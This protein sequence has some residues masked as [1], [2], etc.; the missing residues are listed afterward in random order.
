MKMSEVVSERFR[1]PQSQDF[2]SWMKRFELGAQCTNL[3][4]EQK[5]NSFLA[6]LESPCQELAMS[7]VKKYKTD[8]EP[9]TSPAADVRA[10]HKDLWKDLIAYVSKKS[11][12]V[13][14]RPELRLHNQWSSLR[15]KEHE[16]VGSY[17]HRLE[18]LKCQMAEQDKPFLADDMTTW[19]TFVN[20][21][22]EEIRWHIKANVKGTDLEDTLERAEAYEEANKS[23][24]PQRNGKPEY[25][26][27]GT[28]QNAAPLERRSGFQ[29]DNS[30]RARGPRAMAVSDDRRSRRPRPGRSRS[31]TSAM[32]TTNDDQR[33]RPPPAPKKALPE[34]GSR[35]EICFPF[36]KNQTCKHADNCFRI[37]V[38]NLDQKRDVRPSVNKVVTEEM[39]EKCKRMLNMQ[40]PRL[41]TP[42]AAA[43]QDTPP[44]G[45]APAEE[46]SDFDFTAATFVVASDTVLAGDSEERPGVCDMAYSPSSTPMT[47]EEEKE[48]DEQI[49]ELLEDIGVEPAEWPKDGAVPKLFS[50]TSTDELFDELCAQISQEVDED[51]SILV[52]MVTTREDIQPPAETVGEANPAP[53]GHRV[54]WEYSWGPGDPCYLQVVEPDYLDSFYEQGQSIPVMVHR[55]LQACHYRTMH[56]TQA[57]ELA[58]I[59]LDDH[60]P[61]LAGEACGFLSSIYKFFKND[62]PVTS[63]LLLSWLAHRTARP[64]LSRDEAR[65]RAGVMPQ[66]RPSQSSLESHNCNMTCAESDRAEQALLRA[67]PEETLDEAESAD[68]QHSTSDDPTPELVD[69]PDTSSEADSLDEAEYNELLVYFTCYD[70]ECNMTCGEEDR[71]EQARLQAWHGNVLDADEEMLQAVEYEANGPRPTPPPSPAT[72]PPPSI[73]ASNLGGVEDSREQLLLQIFHEAAQQYDDRLLRAVAEQIDELASLPIFPFNEHD[74]SPPDATCYTAIGD[75]TSPETAAILKVYAGQ[76]L[77]RALIDTGSRVNLI[78]GEL[79]DYI[80]GA[81][82]DEPGVVHKP[83]ERVSG[84]LH[85]ASTHQLNIRGETTLRLTVVPGKFLLAKFLVA[86]RLMT[87]MIWGDHL[88]GP[89]QLDCVIDLGSKQMLTRRLGLTLDLDIHNRAELR[90]RLKSAAASHKRKEQ[91]KPLVPGRES[92]RPPKLVRSLSAMTVD[93]ARDVTES[94]VTE[95]EESESEHG[96]IS[97]DET[98]QRVRNLASFQRWK[99]NQRRKNQYRRR[100]PL[101]ADDPTICAVVQFRG[102]TLAAMQRGMRHGIGESD[103]Y[104]IC[105]VDMK[106]GELAQTFYGTSPHREAADWCGGSPHSADVI[107][108]ICRQKG[109]QS[110]SHDRRRLSHKGYRW[111]FEGDATET[112]YKPGYQERAATR[113]A[114][115]ENTTSAR[116]R[117][118]TSKIPVTRLTQRNEEKPSVCVTQPRDSKKRRMAAQPPSLPPSEPTSRSA[119]PVAPSRTYG[120]PRPEVLHGPRAP[121][122]TTATTRAPTMPPAATPPGPARSQLPDEDRP[123]VDEEMPPLV[124]AWLQQQLTQLE[125]IKRIEQICALANFDGSQS[126]LTRSPDSLRSSSEIIRFTWEIREPHSRPRRD[127][128]LNKTPSGPPPRFDSQAL[129]LDA[130]Q[131]F[132]TAVAEEEPTAEELNDDAATKA[133]FLR[134]KPILEE[135]P[136]E[137]RRYFRRQRNALRKKILDKLTPEER[138]QFVVSAYSDDSS[139]ESSECYEPPS[140]ADLDDESAEHPSSYH[141]DDGDDEMEDHDL[142]E[143]DD[144]DDAD[145]SDLEDSDCDESR[146]A[147]FAVFSHDDDDLLPDNLASP[148]DTQPSP[149][150]SERPTTT[151]TPVLL[152]SSAPNGEDARHARAGP[153][154]AP[155]EDSTTLPVNRVDP[156]LLSRAISSP[157]PDSDEL[158]EHDEVKVAE[159][160]MHVVRVETGEQFKKLQ[161]A[162]KALQR[163]RHQK[164]IARASP[165]A[166]VTSPIPTEPDSP[167]TDV[168]PSAVEVADS[169]SPCISSTVSPL[170]AR[171]DQLG[172]QILEQERQLTTPT[173]GSPGATLSPLASAVNDEFRQRRP[174]AMSFCACPRRPSEVNPHDLATIGECASESNRPLREAATVVVASPECDPDT[175]LMLRRN[176]AAMGLPRTC[177]LSADEFEYLGPSPRLTVLNRNPINA[178]TSIKFFDGKPR[179]ILCIDVKE[180]FVYSDQLRPSPVFVEQL[181]HNNRVDRNKLEITQAVDLQ[182]SRN[183]FPPITIPALEHGNLRIT[184]P[185]SEAADID[186]GHCRFSELAEPV[187]RLTS[188]EKLIVFL[189]YHWL[190]LTIGFTHGDLE[191]SNIV[192]ID[193]DLRLVDFETSTCDVAGVEHMFSA[194]SPRRRQRDFERIGVPENQYD[195]WRAYF[196]TADKVRAGLLARMTARWDVPDTVDYDYAAP[197]ALDDAV[198]DASAAAEDLSGVVVCNAVDSKR[199]PKKRKAPSDEDGEPP[200]AS[201]Q[202]RPRAPGLDRKL[203]AIDEE[204]FSDTDIDSESEGR[205]LGMETAQEWA[206]DCA[207]EHAR[208]RQKCPRCSPDGSSQTPKDPRCSCYHGYRRNLRAQEAQER[209]R[210]AEWD[211]MYLDERAQWRPCVFKSPFSLDPEP[212]VSRIISQREIPVLV[213]TGRGDS[214]RVDARTLREYCENRANRPYDNELSPLQYSAFSARLQADAAINDCERCSDIMSRKEGR[215]L[216][217]SCL[218]PRGRA[219]DMADAA[220]GEL[221]LTATPSP[222]TADEARRKLGCP[223]WNHMYR[224]ATNTWT[225]CELLSPA[226]PGDLDPDVRIR[227]RFRYGLEAD[228]P[229]GRLAPLDYDQLGRLTTPDTKKDAVT[230]CAAVSSP[231]TPQ[232]DEIICALYSGSRQVAKMFLSYADAAKWCGGNRGSIWRACRSRKA[233]RVHAGYHWRYAST[234]TKPPAVPLRP[235]PRL[236]GNPRAVT[237]IDLH[238]GRAV[239]TFR[240]CVEAAQWCEGTS[241]AI[242]KIC[243]RKSRCSHHKGYGW[244]DADLATS[245]TNS[246]AQSGTQNK[247]KATKRGSPHLRVITAMVQPAVG[248]AKTPDVGAAAFITLP[249]WCSDQ[250]DHADPPD[251][252]ESENSRG[253]PIPTAD[254]PAGTPMWCYSRTSRAWVQAHFVRMDTPIHVT[255]QF[256]CGLMDIPRARCRKWRRTWPAQV[257]ASQIALI[258]EREALD[259]QWWNNTPTATPD[260]IAISRE[261]PLTPRDVDRV[262]HRW[263]RNPWNVDWSDPNLDSD[264]NSIAYARR[265]LLEEPGHKVS[266]PMVT[267]RGPLPMLYRPRA[268]TAPSDGTNN[269][270]ETRT[271]AL[272]PPLPLDLP[273]G[274]PLLFLSRSANQWKRAAFEGHAASPDLPLITISVFSTPTRNG[275]EVVYRRHLMDL[276]V[277]RCREYVIGKAD[278][279]VTPAEHRLVAV[280]E[281]RANALMHGVDVHPSA[282]P[283]ICQHAPHTPR[284]DQHSRSRSSRYRWNQIPVASRQLCSQSTRTAQPSSLLA[285]STPAGAETYDLTH[286]LPRSA[287][288]YTTP[289]SQ[290]SLQEVS[291]IQGL[292]D[293]LSRPS[294]TNMVEYYEDETPER[295]EKGDCTWDEICSD[296]Y[297]VTSV[298]PSVFDDPTKIPVVTLYAGIGGFSLGLAHTLSGPQLSPRIYVPVLAI[299]SEQLIHAAHQLT[300]PGIPCARFFMSETQDTLALIETYLP[301]RLW[302]RAWVHASPS[303]R[304]ASAV[305]VRRDEAMAYQT[306]AWAVNLMEIMRPAIWTLEQAPTLRDYFADEYPLVAN[307]RMADHCTLPQDRTRMIISS[308][309]LVLPERPVHQETVRSALCE[310]RGWPAEPFSSAHRIRNSYYNERGIDERAFAVTSG[311]H[312]VGALP[313]EAWNEKH[314]MSWIERARL[315]GMRDPSCLKFLAGTNEQMRRKMVANCVPPPFSA[316]IQVAVDDALRTNSTSSFALTTPAPRVRAH[317][318]TNVVAAAATLEHEVSG[319]SVPA[320]STSHGAIETADLPTIPAAAGAP[321]GLSSQAAIFE[322]QAA[323][324]PKDTASH[325]ARL[326]PT[327]RSDLTQLDAMSDADF[328]AEVNRRIP[329]TGGEKTTTPFGPT[330]TRAELYLFG[331]SGELLALP[332]EARVSVPSVAA[333]NLEQALYDLAM[334]VALRIGYRLAA[335]TGWLH[336]TTGADE[337]EIFTSHGCKLVDLRE[338]L[339]ADRSVWPEPVWIPP[340]DFT[341]YRW[342]RDDMPARIS[343]AVRACR[344]SSDERK[345]LSLR[346]WRVAHP[347]IAIDDD[348]GPPPANHSWAVRHGNGDVGAQSDLVQPITRK[349]FE[350]LFK[351]GTPDCLVHNS[352]NARQ[353]AQMMDLLWR[354]RTLFLQPSRLGCADVPPHEIE[355]TVDKPIAQQPYRTNPEKQAIIMKEVDKLKKL[356]CVEDSNSPWASPVVLVQ[357]P[358][359]SWRFCVDYRALNAHTVRDVYPLPRIQDTLHLLN[360]QRYFTTLDLLQGFFQL[361]LSE[362]AKKKT[363]FVTTQGLFQFRALAMGLA[364]A[365]ATFQRCVD[366][367]M[368]GLKWKCVLVYIDD[369][370]VYSPTWE[371]HLL[372]LE[373]VFDRLSRHLLFVKPH[374]CCFGADSLQYL[375]HVVTRDGLKPSTKHIDAVREFP[376]PTTKTQ[377]K[378]FLGLA[379]FNRAFI[380]NFAKVTMPLRHLLSNDIPPN[381]HMPITLTE[382]QAPIERSLWDEDCET[383]FKRLKHLLTTAPILAFP[384]WEQSFTLRT[385][386]SYDGLGAVLRQGDRVIAYISRGLTEAEKKL[387]VRELEISAVLFACEQLRP[388]LESNNRPFLIQTD[389]R[390]LTWLTNVKHDGKLARWALRLSSFPFHLEHLKGTD[391]AEADALSR[392]PIAFTSQP[393]LDKAPLWFEEGSRL[394]SAPARGDDV[395]KSLHVTPDSSAATSHLDPRLPRPAVGVHAVGIHWQTHTVDPQ[396]SRTELI[397]EQKRDSY[398][399]FIRNDLA[400]AQAVA[401]RNAKTARDGN[402]TPTTE[403][404]VQHSGERF[405]IESDMLVRLDGEGPD[406]R[407]QIVVPAKYR[408]T[409]LWN[410][411]NSAFGGHAGRD[412]TIARLQA[413]YFWPGLVQDARS[414]TRTCQ[415]CQKSRATRP[416]NRG[417]MQI[418]EPSTKPFQTLGCDLLGPLPLSLRG[419]RWCLTV[420]DH[421]SHWPILIPLPNKEATT[422]A[423]AIFDNVI[424]E[425]GAC[426]RLLSDREATLAAPVMEAL[427]KL[428]RT[429]RVF[430]AAFTPSTNGVTERFHRVVNTALRTYANLSP[431]SRDWE[432][433]LKICQTVYR[434][435][436]LTNTEYTPFFLLYGRHPVM[437]QDIFDNSTPKVRVPKHDYVAKL[438]QELARA[439][440]VL[441]KIHEKLKTR[442]KKYY[443]RHRVEMEFEIGDTVLVYYPPLES[444]KILW[445]WRGPFRIVEKVSPLSYR[446]QNPETGEIYKELA[447]LNRLA[448]YYEA[449]HASWLKGGDAEEEAPSRLVAMTACPATNNEAQEPK[450]DEEKNDAAHVFTTTSN[451]SASEKA[452]EN[453]EPPEMKDIELP[454]IDVTFRVEKKANAPLTRAQHADARRQLDEEESIERALEV[455]M[456]ASQAVVDLTPDQ[457]FAAPTN[458]ELLRDSPLMRVGDHIIVKLDEAAYEPLVPP[459]ER[460]AASRPG[461]KARAAPARG[462]EREAQDLQWRVAEIL[463]IIPPTP[464]DEGQLHVHFYDSNEPHKDVAERTFHPA[465]RDTTAD[466]DVYDSAFRGTIAK[467]SHFIEYKDT[468]PYS[469]LLTYPFALTKQRQIP[470]RIL[471]QLLPHL[472]IQVFR[473]PTRR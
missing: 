72:M 118:T 338:Q 13:G 461:R 358:D 192:R 18:R 110:M 419:N 470:N 466:K 315:Q 267:P 321:T 253:L 435:T 378:S 392:N 326:E 150:R 125:A 5:V 211:A 380:E 407:R 306:T 40:P 194:R 343:C 260:L 147:V 217:C 339:D 385:D 101:D 188:K 417:L 259:R 462:A 215:S 364:N 156:S 108:K 233:E 153:G 114:L 271:R 473:Q 85:G 149:P 308:H 122:R 446:L 198:D 382:G 300:L 334:Q 405:K 162:H 455:A 14:T 387:D 371:Q 257:T 298:S 390:N 289:P 84:S 219:E 352:L 209:V 31:P 423:E 280:R 283:N 291:R 28:T 366:V 166:G 16:S 142:G 66:S 411:H 464:T 131:L 214:K 341:H 409:V 105:A 73:P 171:C 206:E 70:G 458:D 132:A 53:S 165:L 63:Q 116:P 418:P 307:F 8:H 293:M 337:D 322:P 213:F 164:P 437:P 415:E 388:Y 279:P 224:D 361:P 227:V 248:E 25:P 189:K 386:A 78:S 94:E 345:A 3:Q 23:I 363:A 245:P 429:K 350:E 463:V 346:L 432:T 129:E 74:I 141:E 77:C 314:H 420:I 255:A 270:E 139:E 353:Q 266:E 249:A 117:A 351:H 121:P 155:G 277:A 193:G 75:S 130:T 223:V 65:T 134:P 316:A 210:T 170:A 82:D 9:P 294:A 161:R 119:A 472:Y 296:R 311:S 202:P 56:D 11:A 80:C 22:R 104:P 430:T 120:P 236:C 340:C 62:V 107:L 64:Q 27:S 424:C 71:V 275:D 376:T 38:V 86:E 413:A 35:D 10:Y 58:L 124:A 356:G 179:V 230:Q 247:T 395:I 30:S 19:T 174:R 344:S 442:M 225:P 111:H 369:V 426:E 87:D 290:V 205:Y 397:E 158:S 402:D 145:D 276:P 292:L 323:G 301:K 203:Q 454:P 347:D 208:A 167:P 319:Q 281:T 172:L 320:P 443:D 238:S 216:K 262:Q 12:F 457:A 410:A 328:A 335:I 212:R 91:T 438:Q 374:K 357:K 309:P 228:V 176:M 282:T 359:K 384:D 200:A 96:T 181:H 317:D 396:P 220:D 159:R 67:W 197:E 399:K 52:A 59:F 48:V 177:A 81:N 24:V 274:T 250:I 342:P 21:L 370:C 434:F 400:R 49:D 45:S 46:P 51:E 36:L 373:Q 173:A 138:V 468:V 207:N 368:G 69:A 354:Y 109:E 135:D 329:P 243:S 201:K 251:H 451:D 404:Y 178:N 445:C 305:N 360:G 154:V 297:R 278:A 218:E 89:F 2:A 453:D 29:R 68:D 303:C 299:E 428:M 471:R 324:K 37:H 427:V 252:S 185:E 254:T 265:I 264:E 408:K 42:A 175:D 7:F 406:T 379:S 160:E 97:D 232:N 54:Y 288:A 412:R 239:K 1:G 140:E 286:S 469:T 287:V 126:T 61:R 327:S 459:A 26:S 113:H 222:T 55:L 92:A 422:I 436:T 452:S 106:T 39:R 372:D 263:S 448:K 79:Y 199:I 152:E 425:H 377:L 330:T 123:V 336:A 383:S 362:E 465:Y 112:T 302:P 244:R 157:T 60:A 57:V 221:L 269:N 441:R 440:D 394:P 447:N 235:A 93:D 285:P 226:A 133:M 318:D 163:L 43:C 325:P 102:K 137:G 41:E 310:Y 355:V 261:A 83:L 241:S 6:Y 393:I 191:L 439:H 456:Q 168:N 398:C 115:P 332:D 240:T 144:E 304:L 190:T 231:H 284:P 169:S 416:R 17:Y 136:A 391:N 389:H 381:L 146:T 34:P 258:A 467:P 348:T 148:V 184:F 20:G 186:L 95:S 33:Y 44:N 195:R 375:G 365:P 183:N 15:Q 460:A 414:W 272:W 187:T 180:G 127:I 450:T 433:S 237:A 401:Q 242:S 229:S 246:H 103:I 88:L 128:R 421:F 32:A 349:E 4:D 76:V 273:V 196:D 151:V 234:P 331:A 403:T 50:R 47:P 313:N 333:A 449:E 256:P 99:K 312:Q 431:T 268:G 182:C 90:A 143:E 204:D 367:I 444:S 98:H 295:P 100:Q